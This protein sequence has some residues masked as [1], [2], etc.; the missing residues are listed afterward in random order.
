MSKDEFSRFLM[1]NEESQIEAR[2]GEG[3]FYEEAGREQLSKNGQKYH[4][5]VWFLV[6]MLEQLQWMATVAQKAT[7][8]DRSIGH[9]E[10]LPRAGALESYDRASRYE[11]LSYDGPSGHDGLS[12]SLEHLSS[13]HWSA[14]ICNVTTGDAAVSDVVSKAALTDGS[15]VGTNVA[16]GSLAEVEDGVDNDSINDNPDGRRADGTAGGERTKT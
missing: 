4:R 11:D 5:R 6:Y 9:H 16:C 13:T 2:S 3:S 14:G 7:T 10:W 8:R 15:G 12:L 1:A